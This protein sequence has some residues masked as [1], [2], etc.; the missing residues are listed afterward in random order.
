MLVYWRVP[1]RRRAPA[2]PAVVTALLL[3]AVT[4]CSSPA[5]V[6]A[7]TGEVPTPSDAVPAGPV[8]AGPTGTPDPAATPDPAGQGDDL[9]L[10]GDGLSL[11]HG[12][13][14]QPL[15]FG[16]APVADVRAALTA[17]LGDVA[18][19]GAVACP[20]GPRVELTADG[21]TVL[22]DG[23]RFVGWTDVGA[24][25]RALTTTDGVGTGTRLPDLRS[26]LPDVQV[27][28]GGTTWSSAGGLSGTLSG[29][30]PAARVAV[31]SAGQTCPH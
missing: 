23:D 8:A 4:A 17:A 13:T 5:T 26:A 15:P 12:D 18:E 11:L 7:S 28:A 21:F 22:L 27:P 2:G 1:A 3:A 10:Q 19:T 29:S 25:D 16:T 9:V 31:I 24:P 14:P 30:D 20:Q 6:R